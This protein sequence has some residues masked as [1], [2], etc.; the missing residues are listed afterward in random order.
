MDAYWRNIENQ[1][2]KLRTADTA[3]KVIAICPPEPGTSTGHG[4][5]GGSGG[6]Y[7]PC[8]ALE[9]AGWRFVQWKAK[10]WW[11]MRAP[12]GDILTYVEGDIY[13]GYHI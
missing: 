7:L 8:D 13:K 2:D 12:N 11:A 4:W 6:D 1:L 5:W 3:E 10:Y 9:C